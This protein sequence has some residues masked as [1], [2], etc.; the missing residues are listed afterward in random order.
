MEPT[1]YLV[2]NEKVNTDACPFLDSI[3]LSFFGEVKKHNLGF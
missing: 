2:S 3:R 1:F